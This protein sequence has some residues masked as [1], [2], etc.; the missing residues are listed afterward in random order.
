MTIRKTFLFTVFM[1]LS[2]VI[3]AERGRVTMAHGTVV[4]DKGTN[5]RGISLSV[6]SMQGFAIPTDTKTKITALSTTYGMN[7]LRVCLEK[8]DSP[9]GCNKNI[10]DSLVAWT[11]NANL[12]LILSIGNS[13]QKGSF[14]VTQAK[15]F[16]N[17]Y[18]SRYAS[19]TH[20]IYEIHNEPETECASPLSAST[21]DME[22]QCYNI[23]RTNAPN[24]HIILFSNSGVATSTSILADINAIKA[25][26]ASFANASVGYHGYYACVQAR[27]GGGVAN[28]TETLALD[29]VI[30]AGYSLICTEFDRENAYTGDDTKN[31]KL[32]KFYEARN[33]SWIS[34]FEATT[35]VSTAYFDFPS[36]NVKVT[37]VSGNTFTIEPD[38]RGETTDW[39]YW[40]FA[41]CGA[42][43][44]TLTFNLPTAAVKPNM[45][46][47]PVKGPLVSFDAGNTWSYINSSGTWD[48]TFSYT[49]T[50]NAEVRFSNGMP[51]TQKNYDVFIAP[52]RTNPYL[53]LD[54]LVMSEGGRAVDRIIIKPVTGT[55]KFKVLITA[56]H[57]AQEMMASY[58]IEG[59][60]PTILNDTWLRDNVEFCIIPFVDKDGVEDGNQSKIRV[61]NFNADYDPLVPSVWA[62]TRTLRSWVPTWKGSPSKLV[63]SFDLHCPW[64][65]EM[66]NG[67]NDNIT[68]WGS[69]TPAVAIEEQKF[70][71]LFKKT[72]NGTLKATTTA[73]LPNCAS[74]GKTSRSWADAVLGVKLPITLEYAFTSNSGA[75]ITQANT[76]E[77]GIDLANAMKL[78]LQQ[79]P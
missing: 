37:N 2:T 41:I 35:G 39:F 3:F 18:A 20:V 16:W 25:K 65:R 58:E 44:K 49:F 63:L 43:G 60:I 45:Q 78:Y 62:A 64:I 53:H 4:S 47:L 61:P 68:F 22:W 24:T 42:K 76:R 6:D 1:M 73:Y 5:L 48:R 72:N 51:Y 33:V 74:T 7:T 8:F 14:N 59:I 29:P 38:L 66:S 31:G 26:G 57:H 10:A 28:N 11:S 50:T 27:D 12:Y 69:T 40:H 54:T 71:T 46:Y 9:T 77:W 75:L 36:G 17:Y 52:Y 23:I 32:V 15:S 79:L 67:T 55:P 21:I 19:R 56:R 34:S 70:I 30:A 13:A